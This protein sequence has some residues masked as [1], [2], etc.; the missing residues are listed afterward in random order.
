M[1]PADLEKFFR[2]QRREESVSRAMGSL[3]DD[4]ELLRQS[5]VRLEYRKTELEAELEKCN[6]LQAHSR[7][8]EMLRRNARRTV[9]TLVMLSEAEMNVEAAK[10]KLDAVLAGCPCGSCRTPCYLTPRLCP[11]CGPVCNGHEP[12]VTVEGEMA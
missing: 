5:L 10:R 1:D 6:R 12:D 11:L 9:T 2:E 8:S 3:P 4:R 7:T